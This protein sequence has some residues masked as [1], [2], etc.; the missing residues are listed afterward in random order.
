MKSPSHGLM[1]LGPQPMLQQQNGVTWAIELP[2]STEL[3]SVDWIGAHLRLLG[4]WEESGEMR[5]GLA[6][7]SRCLK[8]AKY[9]K[10]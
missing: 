5:F 8:K 4:V 9:K 10:F 1:G 2:R 6:E 3:E 7:L